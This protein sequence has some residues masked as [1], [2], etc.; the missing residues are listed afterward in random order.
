MGRGLYQ[1]EKVFREHVD[2]CSEI[3]LPH[4]ELDLRN[5]IYQDGEQSKLDPP[6]SHN[7]RSS[8][9][10]FTGPTMDVVGSTSRSDDRTQRR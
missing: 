6:S 2:R 10:V 9:S 5:A 7:R 4:L 1:H 8:L 3:L